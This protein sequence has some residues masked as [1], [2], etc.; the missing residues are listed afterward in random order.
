[1]TDSDHTVAL[2]A[3]TTEDEQPDQPQRVPSAY[4]DYSPADEHP[5]EYATGIVSLGF[6]ATA[7]RRGV[8]L[9]L[10]IALAAML[11]GLGLFVKFPPAYKATTTVLLKPFPDTQPTDGILTDIA[12]AES[13]TVAQS[14]VQ[15]LGLPQAS[16]GSFLKAYSVTEITDQVVLITV[17]APSNVEAVRRANAVAAAFLR[18]RA[19]QAQAQLQSAFDGLDKAAADAKLHAADLQNQV[20]QLEAQP[21]S[22]IQSSKLAVRQSQLRQAQTDAATIHDAVQSEKATEQQ[23]TMQVVQNSKV[24]DAA[25]PAAATHHKL[26]VIYA[27]SSLILGLALGMGFVIV[28]ALVS[29]RLR[30][31][32]DIAHALGA[33]VTLSVGSPK[34]HW[35]PV[36]RGQ[37]RDQKRMVTHLRNAVPAR[38]PGAPGLA[39]VAVD[40]AQAAAPS[41]VSLAVSCAQEGQQV[42]VADLA[43]GA[44]AARLLGAGKPGIRPVK[45][46]GAH[47]VV[48]V[49]GRDNVA[50]VGPLP[51][52]SSQAQLGQASEALVAAY[53]S[54]DLLLT[55]VTID[56]AL[57]ADH[58]ATWATSAVVVVTAGRSSAARIHAVGELVRL[59]GMSPVSAVL[60]DADKSDE[61][62]GVT[63]TPVP[64]APAGQGLGIVG[65]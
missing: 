12:M 40:N 46:S 7:L 36:R 49:P 6:I 8:R 63:H 65:R 33:P 4:D 53:A 39:A 58:L 48:A 50:P 18:F 62:T 15:R 19:T 30:R 43:R 51:Q 14:A 1:M 60:L 20:K 2:P 44:P 3:V 9:W 23:A 64:Q 24:V 54:A 37:G 17:G 55:L 5:G 41:L 32:D 29:D 31:R 38:S 25:T 61:S 35:L 57:G 13:R 52:K 21:P 10:A 16:V 27:L 42:V 34:L 45:V 11:A 47:L 26:L 59:A 56:P 28:R 22:P